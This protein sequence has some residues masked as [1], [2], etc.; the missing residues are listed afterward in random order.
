MKVV[1]AVQDNKGWESVISPRFGRAFGYISYSDV[2]GKI[3]FHPNQENVNAGH[4]AGIQ[5]AQTIINL[6]ASCVITGGSI[7]PKA[8]DV[9]K[10]A[11]IKMVSQV[12]E[13]TV[14]DALRNFIDG[15]YLK[16]EVSDL[17]KLK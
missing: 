13:I 17:Q 16:L 12:G 2:T 4:G 1:F 14:K 8:F 5:A 7:G 3:L 9:L 15:K 11:A 6:Q 10:N